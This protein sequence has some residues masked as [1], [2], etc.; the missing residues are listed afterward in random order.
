[1]LFAATPQYMPSAQLQSSISQCLSSNFVV[2]LRFCVCRRHRE[3]ERTMNAIVIIIARVPFVYPIH[4]KKLIYSICLCIGK[5]STVLGEER[6]FAY[7]SNEWEEIAGERERESDLAALF[8][9]CCLCCV[10]LS[11]SLPP[12][13]VSTTSSSSTIL[14]QY[15][16]RHYQWLS[17]Q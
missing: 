16:R 6:S 9:L 4:I 17:S 2:V 12:C 3:R 10:R 11:P 1:M 8:A 7:C 13:K 15:H 14:S 5:K